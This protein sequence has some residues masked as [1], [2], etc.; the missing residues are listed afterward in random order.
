[1]GWQE[2]DWGRWFGSIWHNGQPELITDV[3]GDPVSE[4]FTVSGDG[5]TVAGQVFEGQYLRWQR[6]ASQHGT[7]QFAGILSRVPSS[8]RY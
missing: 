8:F 2:A 1:M 4:A 5:S 7:R 6:L 3:N